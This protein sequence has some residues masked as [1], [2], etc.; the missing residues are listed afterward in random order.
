MV[1]NPFLEL[2]L[3]SD[4]GAVTAI[5]VRATIIAPDTGSLGASWNRIYR[6]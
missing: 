1:V 3:A 6:E 4:K 5:T 2:N